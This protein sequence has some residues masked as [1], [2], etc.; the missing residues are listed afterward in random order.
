MPLDRG[1]FLTSGIMY[2]RLPSAS[3]LMLAWLA[4]GVLTLGRAL[5]YAEMGVMYPRSGGLYVFLS[6]AYGQFPA[7]LF[8]WTCLLVILTGQIAAIA[9]GFSAY[10][11]YFFPSL[12][13][14]HALLSLS[15]AGKQLTIAANHVSAATAILLL[16]VI[17]YVNARS[18]NDL[19]ALLTVLKMAGIVALPVLALLFARAHPA[20]RP[21]IP[22]SLGSSHVGAAFGISMIA[23]LWAYDGWQ[24]VCFAAGEIHNPH[25][26]IPRAL[27]LGVAAVV[28]SF[29]AVNLAY[30]YALPPATLSGTLRVAERAATTMIGAPGGAVFIS[31]TVMIS[32]FGCCAAMMLVCARLFF[33]MAR[34]GVFPRFFGRV[35]PRF[36]TPH[37]AVV[38]TTLWSM[39][40]ALSGSYEQLYTY[41]MFGGLIFAVLAGSAL[42]VL[43]KKTARH[44][45]QLSRVGIPGC[46]R[47]FHRRNAAAGV[48]H[49]A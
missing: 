27:S 15:L 40:F 23:V 8:G 47:D 1:I 4:G 30:V 28:V 6:E 5:T 38:L 25:R 32:A 44:S 21:L 2:Q 33:A 39:V 20:W 41:V 3:M 24:Y 10:L 26:N 35:H 7:F 14:E 42:F 13:P 16:G 17:N 12:S 49:A 11:S 36:G 19:N 22:P 9:I 29:I 43:R 45:P 46:P 34:E 18:S 37:T 31:L 48:Q